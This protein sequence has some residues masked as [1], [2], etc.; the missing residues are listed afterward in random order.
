MAD[1]LNAIAAPVA[2]YVDGCISRGELPQGVR[3]R[4]VARANLYRDPDQA[5]QEVVD[6]LETGEGRAFKL[7][8]KSDDAPEHALLAIVRRLGAGPGG[9]AASVFQE[10]VGVVGLRSPG[11]QAVAAAKAIKARAPKPLSRSQEIAGEILRAMQRD[12]AISGSYSAIEAAAAKWGAE[13]SGKSRLD[14][15]E[16]IAVRT[17][18]APGITRHGAISNELRRDLSEADRSDGAGIDPAATAA[19]RANNRY[20]GL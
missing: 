11:Q 18:F 8:T 1:E 7:P 16:I 6:F 9:A 5:L 3:D 12:G 19:L 20:A 17:Q 13:L 4:L 14:M 2:K 10:I 15:A